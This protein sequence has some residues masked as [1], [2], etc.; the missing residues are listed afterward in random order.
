[1]PLCSAPTITTNG[2]FSWKSEIDNWPSPDNPIT[3][4]PFFFK[5]VSVLFKLTT[6][7]TGICS[8]APAATFATVPV[9]PADLL[10]GMIIPL[11]SNA[12]A[13]LMIAPTLCGS[14]I[15]SKA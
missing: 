14:V 7:L 12:S 2:A 1:M 6:L 5:S 10:W 9:N 8:K 13:D 11:Q 3:R 15:P 4:K